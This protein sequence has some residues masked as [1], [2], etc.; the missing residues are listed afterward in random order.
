MFERHGRSG[1]RTIC[2]ALVGW[3]ISVSVAGAQARRRLHGRASSHLMSTARAG[4]YTRSVPTRP[5]AYNSDT[6]HPALIP[7]EVPAGARRRTAIPARPGMKRPARAGI[8]AYP[9]LERKRQDR[10]V[11]PEVAGSSPVAP[12]K[13]FPCKLAGCVVL[14]DVFARSVWATGPDLSPG[15]PICRDFSKEN[16]P[17]TNQVIRGSFPKQDCGLRWVF[18][19]VKLI[20][21]DA[22]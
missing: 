5:A 6:E 12:A 21:S 1:A 17:R 10:P 14:A 18:G 4:D 15:I 8:P 11:T 13:H 20:K 16:G 22:A 7:H 2:L 3:H 19:I 9:R